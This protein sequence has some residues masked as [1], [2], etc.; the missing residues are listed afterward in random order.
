MG[1]KKKNQI[2]VVGVKISAL[3]RKEN[4]VEVPITPDQY[5]NDVNHFP[6]RNIVLTHGTERINLGQVVE[7]PKRVRQTEPEQPPPCAKRKE[8]KG[9]TETTEA[10]SFNIRRFDRYD[11]DIIAKWEYNHDRLILNQ[12]YPFILKYFIEGKSIIVKCKRAHDRLKWLYHTWNNQA[13][14]IKQM[15]DKMQLEPGIKDE[16]WEDPINYIINAQIVHSVHND[17][18]VQRLIEVLDDVLTKN[19]IDDDDPGENEDIEDEE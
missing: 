13:A 11:K 16:S 3:M 8:K 18:A 15:Y 14:F 4:G 6:T 7:V 17:L 9:G 1:R 12:D 5:K 19:E 2:P 10:P